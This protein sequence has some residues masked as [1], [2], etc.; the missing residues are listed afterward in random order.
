MALSVAFRGVGAE[1]TE[2]CDDLQDCV[3]SQG[4]STKQVSD[5]SQCRQPCFIDV[6]VIKEGCAQRKRFC[7]EG[8]KVFTFFRDLRC[9][10]CKS[11][12]A[13]Q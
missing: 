3:G 2:T 9:S 7:P 4:C 13:L 5:R 10:G 11:V 1:L 6:L 8:A 12:V